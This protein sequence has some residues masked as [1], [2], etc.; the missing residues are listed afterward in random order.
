MCHRCSLSQRVV[1]CSKC[2]HAREGCVFVCSLV[3]LFFF[4]TDKRVPDARIFTEYF[5]ALLTI[6]TVRFFLFAK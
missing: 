1:L 4:T 6:F 3:L 2:V 5:L